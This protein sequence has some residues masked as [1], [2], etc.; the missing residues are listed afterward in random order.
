[1]KEQSI[2]KQCDRSGARVKTMATVGVMTALTCIVAPF[3]IPLPFTGVPIT[4]ATLV[5]CLSAL[6]LG[7][8]AGTLSCAI[9]LL[10]G[11]TG[12]PVFSGFTGGL[13]KI[14][15]PTGGYLMAFLLLAAICG[16]AAERWPGRRVPYLIGMI[17]GMAVTYAI[18]TVWLA[19]QLGI[20]FVAAL[21]LG[22]IPFLPGDAFKMV[23][24]IVLGFQLRERLLRVGVLNLKQIKA[25]S[26]GA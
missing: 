6:L 8:K 23:V 26:N 5:I 24:V 15:G 2:E 20:T 10:I 14:G 19:W 25:R 17:I 18:G 11:L 16:F 21:P 7:M 1:M 4:F 13:G 3:S 22:V 12:V 9:Y